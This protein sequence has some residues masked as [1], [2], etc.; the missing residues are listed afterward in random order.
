MAALGS[1]ASSPRLLLLLFV[2]A[3]VAGM[4]TLGHAD[5]VYVGHSAT[6]HHEAATLMALPLAQPGDDSAAPGEA[7]VHDHCMSWTR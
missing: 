4:H 6:G 1:W 5:P 3:G 2:L 7:C